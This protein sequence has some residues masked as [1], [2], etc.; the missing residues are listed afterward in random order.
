[1]G[2]GQTGGVGGSERMEGVES[3]V[4]SAYGGHVEILAVSGGM[5]SSWPSCSHRGFT[6]EARGFATGGGKIGGI[7]GSGQTGGVE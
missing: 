6:S 4:N 3:Y 1:M 5:C 7:G 2:G